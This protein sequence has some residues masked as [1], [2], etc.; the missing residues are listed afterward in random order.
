MSTILSGAEYLALPR[1]SETWLLKY[2]LPV[3]GAMTLYGDPKIGK[4]YAAIQLALALTG[5]E[6]HWMEFPVVTVGAV[7]Y[8]QLD[9]PRSLWASRLEQL[10]ATGEPIGQLH[11][12][13]RETLN[14]WP[15]DILLPS[16]FELL[17]E[18]VKQIAPIAVVIDTVR[19][20]HSGDEN[21][22]TTMRNVIAA[23]VAATQPAALI[24]ISHARKPNG[25]YPPDL[26]TDQRG[27]SYVVGRMDAIVRFTKKR[28]YYSGRAIEEGS[29]KISRQD[30]GFWEVDNSEWMIHVK[31]V[32]ADPSLTSLRQRAASLAT[33][34]GKGEEACRSALRRLGE[35]AG[36]IGGSTTRP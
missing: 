12:A 10:Q 30:S 4:S 17:L 26:M 3:G 8:V 15:F 1:E 27:S 13:D 33:H 32:L 11:L 7:V 35:S 19:E 16:H 6:T 34:T 28:L 21:D 36:P 24:L 22:S 20:A 18:A 29:M 31:A 25:D 9:T 2:L 14:T 23:L 5:A